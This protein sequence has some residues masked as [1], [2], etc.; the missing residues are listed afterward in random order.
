MSV[1][2]TVLEPIEDFP[3]GKHPLVCRVLKDAFQLRPPQPKYSEF[4]SVDKV[5]CHIRSWG[6]NES[7]S[8]QNLSWKLAM[9]MALS[10]ASRSSDLSRLSVNHVN[11][12]PSRT[13]FL[14]KGLAKQSRSTHLP[15]EVSF[16]KFEDPI[17]C[18]VDCL[19]QY[20]VVTSAFRS[21]TEDKIFEAQTNC[22]WQYQN[23]TIQWYHRLLPDGSNPSWVQQEW[24]HQFF[25]LT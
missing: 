7:L 15:Q 12:F 10:S 1:L 21:K 24:T 13:V 4:W 14:P 2:S 17:L 3:I 6:S 11:F 22:S 18:P 20:L 9:I 8:F 23:L 25:R 5:L 16:S 19:Q